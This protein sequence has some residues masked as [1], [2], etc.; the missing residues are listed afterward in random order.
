MAAEAVR[1]ITAGGTSQNAKLFRRGNAISGAPSI[2]GSSQ[3]PNPPMRMGKITKNI[4]KT[5]W[6]V[7]K[8]L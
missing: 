5:P 8:V 6:A 1:R 4:I 3:F 7:T 2:K